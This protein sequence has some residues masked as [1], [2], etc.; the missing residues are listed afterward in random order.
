MAEQDKNDSGLPAMPSIKLNATA[1]ALI[2]ILALPLAGVLFPTCLVL[3]VCMAPTAVS[4]LFDR[5]REKYLVI[6]TAMLNFCG[7]LP[8]VAELWAAGQT[9][10]AAAQSLADPL[11]W[12][13]AYGAAGTGWLLHLGMPPIVAAYHAR[14]SEARIRHL[15]LRQTTLVEAWGEDVKQNPGVLSVSPDVTVP[16][17]ETTARP[18]IDAARLLGV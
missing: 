2:A 1:K 15:M 10:T 6:S 18:A 8:A 5:G 9:L 13:M 4:F 16:G 14:A 17:G 12:M 11:A 3:A 7:T